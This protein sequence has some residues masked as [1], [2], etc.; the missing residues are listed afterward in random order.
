MKDEVAK[1]TCR[2][3]KQVKDKIE[4][5]EKYIFAYGD[6][7]VS[8]ETSEQIKEKQIRVIAIP[9]KAKKERRKK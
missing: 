8:K 6:V 1:I 3:E 5:G 4:K 9:R 7:K 2:N